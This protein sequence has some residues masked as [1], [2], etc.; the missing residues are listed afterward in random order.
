[1]KKPCN[2]NHTML[3]VLVFVLFV[4]GIIVQIKIATSP[5]IPT[6]LKFLLLR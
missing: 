2:H 4:V 3:Y 5:N 6:W 1:M